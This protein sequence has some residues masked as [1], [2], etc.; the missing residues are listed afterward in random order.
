MAV[1]L[2]STS[3]TPFL[4]SDALF[5][6]EP[7]FSMT[8][9]T[10]EV[11]SCSLPSDDLWNK[12]DMM[13]PTPP[14]SPSH[15]VPTERLI[16][17]ASDA[18]DLDLGLGDFLGLDIP[19]FLDGSDADSDWLFEEIFRE[20]P[21]VAVVA[22][23]SVASCDVKCGELV[24]ELRHDCMWAGHCPAEEHRLKK[25]L[26]TLLS[27]SPTETT[28]LAVVAPQ[29][30][31]RARLDT[32]GSIRPE[33]PLSLSDSELDQLTSPDASDEDA[34]DAD[35]T[36]SSSSSSSE[37]DDHSDDDSEATPTTPT[38]MQRRKIATS[39][40]IPTL[41]PNIH[42]VRSHIRKVQVN[43]NNKCSSVKASM[44]SLTSMADHS[45]SHSDHS[46]HTQRRP[47]D[48]AALVELLGIQTP[49]DSE[50][51]I[52]VVSLG[53]VQRVSPTSATSGKSCHVTSLQPANQPMAVNAPIRLKL[54]VT[55]ANSLGGASPSSSSTSTTVLMRKALPSHPSALVRQQL[56]LA[57]ATAAQQRKHSDSNN[58]HTTSTS[59]KSES[60][61]S[62][63]TSGNTSSSSS[64][65]SSK[66]PRTDTS[67]ITME[68]GS[69]SPRKRSSR[70]GGS[71]SEDSCE[72]RSQHNSMERQRRV[73]L[74][75]AFE[76]LRSLIPD[77][78]ATDRAAKVVIL[79][80][81]ANFCQ[82]LTQREKQFV[83]E[84]DSLQKRQEILR[85]RLALLQRRR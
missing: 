56:Q 54:K 49:S 20:T 67:R 12:F 73:D 39:A 25:E 37:D 29:R 4:D 35:E 21:P 7:L 80:K 18:E 19:G 2:T 38:V 15:D 68:S 79:K 8:A 78:E 84:K 69:L 22:A 55:P 33:T 23:A 57:V 76:F 3:A 9:S 44:A 51:E 10:T 17:D 63:S 66:R 64:G 50:E 13:L 59:R 81:A 42:P 34:K 40:A 5:L 62:K 31:R 72:K 41:P 36:S 26:P 6:S 74:R 14:V 27:T 75:N 58:H 70:T 32:L 30:E 28:L 65:S 85:K 16:G 43:N 83:S 82:G 46:Y 61:S 45:Y 11:I 47:N 77:L 52:D 60:K 53:E 48:N 24:G 1:M 71:D